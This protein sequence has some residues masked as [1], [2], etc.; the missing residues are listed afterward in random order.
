VVIINSKELFHVGVAPFLFPLSGTEIGLKNQREV[1]VFVEI[2]PE[3]F[4]GM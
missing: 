4:Y 2:S 1:S 3:G